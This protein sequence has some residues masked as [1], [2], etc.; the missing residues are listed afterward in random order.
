MDKFE[1][2]KLLNDSRKKIDEF[3]DQI[4]NL[5]LERTSLAKDIITAKKILNKDLFD[6]SRE[7]VIHNKIRNAVADKEINTEKVLE[8]F[9]LLADI[10]KEEQKKYL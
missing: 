2:E 7:E 5:I 1:A 6:S 4:I 3:D 10:S 8:I 9:D